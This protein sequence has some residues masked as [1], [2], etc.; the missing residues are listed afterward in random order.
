MKLSPEKRII[1]GLI[2]LA[3]SFGL[4]VTGANILYGISGGCFAGAVCVGI[5]GLI[6]F[7][8]TIE[9]N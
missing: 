9:P 2:L 8:S 6:L 4:A 3:L 5:Y 7:F 1:I